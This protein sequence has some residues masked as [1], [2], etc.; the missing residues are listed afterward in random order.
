MKLHTPKARL[1]LALIDAGLSVKAAVQGAFG[2]KAK[3]QDTLRQLLAHRLSYLPSDH[4]SK[5]EA[6]YQLALN[7]YDGNVVDCMQAE[8]LLH[9]AQFIFVKRFGPYSLR[10]A[11][12]L[13]LRGLVQGRLGDAQKT[14][15]YHQAADTVYAKVRPLSYMRI[16]N[17]HQLGFAQDRLGMRKEAEATR[18][19]ANELNRLLAMQSIRRRY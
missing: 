8:A 12:A 15:T 11:K 7:Y 4:P 18:K 17:L 1:G 10:V 5:A 6:Q 9:D 16:A 14:H 3:A 13:H 19:L 2:K